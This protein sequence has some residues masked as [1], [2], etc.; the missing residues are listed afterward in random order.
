ML[1][2][3]LKPAKNPKKQEFQSKVGKSRR[4]V[5]KQEK[6]GDDALDN[7][8]PNLNASSREQHMY[9]PTMRAVKVNC[10]ITEVKQLKSKNDTN[11]G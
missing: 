1:C 9:E 2:I 6:V 8:I 4:N 3:Y 7:R 11:D 10:Q 5:K